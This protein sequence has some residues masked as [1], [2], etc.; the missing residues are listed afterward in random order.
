MSLL[1]TDTE[2]PIILGCPSTQSVRMDL[3]QN[4]AS[5]SWTEPT[6]TDNSNDVTLTFTGNAANPG[7]FSLG[8]TPLAYRAVDSEGNI[9]T[10]MFDIVVSGMYFINFNSYRYNYHSYCEFNLQKPCHINIL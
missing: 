8:I 5:V 6:V 1:F 10:C 7:S 9:A 4:F 3:G 2:E